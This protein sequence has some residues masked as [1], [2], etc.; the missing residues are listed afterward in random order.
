MREMYT[1]VLGCKVNYADVQAV[2][3][4]LRLVGDAPAGM[5][6]SEAPVRMADGDAPAGMADVEAPVALVGTCCVTAESEKQSRKEVRR[7]SRRVG[8]E[9]KV[10]VTGCA[11]RLKP[12][13]FA[14][15]A[16]NVTVVTGEP[17]EVATGIKAVLITGDAGTAVNATAVPAEKRSAVKAAGT[18]AIATARTR[19]FL[20]IQ[21]GCASHCSYCVIPQVRGN[22]RSVPLKRV[23]SLASEMV[24]AGYP[25]LVVSG[26]NVGSWRDAGENLP[27]LLGRLAGIDGLKRLRLSSI[28]AT[29]VT[30]ELLDVTERHSCMG[31]HL[32]IPLQSG[33]DGVLASMRR[34]YDT[35]AFRQALELAKM[36]L[37]DINL[38]T[39]VIVGYPAE[40]ET[41]FSNTL[42]YV[43]ACG[44]SK[45]HVFSYSP[46][47]GTLA[48][49]GNAGGGIDGGDG[50]GTMNAGNEGGGMED[51]VPAAEKRRRSGLMRDLS[52]RLQRAH[53]QRKVGLTGEILL[54]APVAP[55]VHG[56]YSLDYTRYI[57][58]G[59]RPGM[60]VSVLA[61]EISE[62]GV[63][64]KVVDC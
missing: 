21:D 38:T 54:E 8:P 53:R 39:D 1:H 35:A 28:E 4:R 40:D 55:G 2:L 44:F 15:L 37:P 51:C 6:G 47:P 5:A 14:G 50:G 61:E 56:G 3:E 31:R 23:L 62:Q 24:A 43:E 45:V 57:V 58:S 48:N 30:Q 11:A 52:R 10:F 64:G 29:H 19:F 42:E 22:P 59:G 63:I 27:G 41:A 20:K 12:D 7:A 16:G 32:H 26:I 9:G 13:V 34:R 25:E 18:S 33:D 49:A 60:L 46:R 17:E 36:I